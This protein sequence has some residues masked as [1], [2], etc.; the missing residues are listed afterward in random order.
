LK[1]LDRHKRFTGFG[2]IYFSERGFV[3]LTYDFR[4]YGKSGGSKDDIG[5]IYKDAA[6][7]I[8]LAKSYNCRHV[9]LVGASM[10]GTT[11][12]I[13]ASMDNTVSGV[14]ALAAPN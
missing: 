5:N 14:V 12:I 4:G 10:G 7:A 3:A 6:A 9:F 13:A 2:N 11:S 8:A 1:N